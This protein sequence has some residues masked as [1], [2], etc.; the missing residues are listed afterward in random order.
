[1]NSTRSMEATERGTQMAIQAQSGWWEIR[2]TRP[3]EAVKPGQTDLN[4]VLH[5]GN[6]GKV[7]QQRRS[8]TRVG[9]G[10]ISMAVDAT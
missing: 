8:M 9:S 6:L 1:M 10:L 5:V 7:F 3:W 2:S 4:F